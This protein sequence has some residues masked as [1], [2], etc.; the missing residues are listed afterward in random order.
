MYTYLYAYEYL[1]ISLYPY[2]PTYPFIQKKPIYKY[3]LIHTTILLHEPLY[4]YIRIYPFNLKP[5]YPFKPL[6]PNIPPH[7]PSH[8][9]IPFYTFTRTHACTSPNVSI[10][11]F[12]P[13]HKP[14]N[15]F[16]PLWYHYVYVCSYTNYYMYLYI[17]IYWIEGR[18]KSILW[19]A[20]VFTF[21]IFMISI[22]RY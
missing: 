2:A 3:R 20:F 22:I 17:G 12:T 19:N 10:H 7:T 11:T 5:E 15:P 14:T 9:C 21:A 16:R 18:W 13:S 8:T 4:F 1:H 6:I